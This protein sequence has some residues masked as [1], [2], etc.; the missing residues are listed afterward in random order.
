MLEEAVAEL[1]PTLETTPED[2]RH[3]PPAYSLQLDQD[4]LMADLSK[5]IIISGQAIA[6]QDAPHP[7]L[8]LMIALRDPRTGDLIAELFPRLPDSSFP[9][10][11]CYSLTVA[12]SCGSYLLEGEVTLCEDNLRNQAQIFDRQPFTVTAQWEKLQSL[13]RVASPTK[14]HPSAPLSPLLAKDTLSS[15]VSPKWQGVLPPR[16]AAKRN[17]RYKKPSPR[18]PSLPKSSE[19]VRS[20]PEAS[21]AYEW[22]LIPELVIISTDENNHDG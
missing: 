8:R 6:H 19:S 15:G 20:T 16:L 4:Q 17:H 12:S 13:L 5:P 9:V 3:Q 18:L 14:S 22:E 10:A 2:N 21:A 7:P 1:S 11:F